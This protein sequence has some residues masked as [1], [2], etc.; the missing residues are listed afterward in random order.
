MA[1]SLL[2]ANTPSI[3]SARKLSAASPISNKNN[4]VFQHIDI[5]KLLSKAKFPV[6]LVNSKIN[7]QDYVMKVF[8]YANNRPHLYFKNEARFCF[9]NHPNIIKPY[10]LEPERETMSK[11]GPQMASYIMMEYAPYGDL[12]DLLTNHGEKVD[13]KLMRTYFRQLIEGIEYLHKNGVA[14]MD[15][16]LE[17]LL[18]G[19]KYMLKI[20]DFDLSTMIGDNK[21]L[22][23]GTKFYRPPEV[24]Q[25][26]CL[27]GKAADIYSAGIVLFTMKTRG[28]LPHAEDK[29][30]NGVDFAGLLYAQNEEFWKSHCKIQKR[31]AEFFDQDFKTLFNMMVSLDPQERPSIAQI[32]QSKWYN[33]PVYTQEEVEIRVGKLF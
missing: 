6:Y 19:D 8:P 30:V 26:S 1:S 24:V 29:R 18:L 22:S 23:K 4:E 16:K 28:M 11:R 33:G 5:S 9:V 21:M 20:A 7:K 17:N 27:D 32:K 14:H 13:D 15:L 3:S 2:G 31:D 25:E 10:Y 12:F